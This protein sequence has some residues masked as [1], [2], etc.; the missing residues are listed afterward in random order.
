MDTKI[1]L[2][3]SAFI[4]FYFLNLF[5]GLALA[6]PIQ[7]T[8][9]YQQSTLNA[10]SKTQVNTTATTSGGITTYS[11]PSTANYGIFGLNVNWLVLPFVTFADTMTFVFGNLFSGT[12]TN[13]EYVSALLTVVDFILLAAFTMGITPYIGGD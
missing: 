11:Q 7:P 1:Q 4:I 10:T 5:V 12:Q 2:A 8:A 6:T 3:F 9:V 13:L